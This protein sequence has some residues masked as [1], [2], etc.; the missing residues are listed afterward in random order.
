VKSFLLRAKQ[1]GPSHPKCSGVVSELSVD[2]VKNKWTRGLCMDES[3][4]A[5]PNPK[6][7]LDRKSGA[8]TL[9][10][11]QVIEKA[12]AKLARRP[13][14]DC[15]ADQGPVEL[16]LALTNGSS[17]SFVGPGSSCGN[18]PAEV[19]DDLDEFQSQAFTITR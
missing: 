15:G 14:P 9:E 17:A 10:H 2:L 11:R 19:A 12:Y 6:Q 5:S 1:G 7:A 4:G 8:L 13:G 16:T 3:R 18:S